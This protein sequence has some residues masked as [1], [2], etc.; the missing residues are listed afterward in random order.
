MKKTIG[1]AGL[2]EKNLKM[3]KKKF[4]LFK[5]LK[6]NDLN[7]FNDLKVDAI[8]IYRE[9][10]VASSLRKFFIKEKYFLFKNLKWFHL[11][12]AGVD[13]YEPSFKKIK[14]I[15]TCGKK[16]QGPNVSE[17]CIAMLLY[18]TRNLNSKNLN[19]EIIEIYNK[20]ALIVGLGSI[21]ISIAEKLN[22]FG[23]K[24]SAITLSSKP[25]YTF[26]NKIYNSDAL[27]KIVGEYDIVINSSALTKITKN[28]F[29]QKIFSKMKKKSYFIN[30]S[31]GLIV[32]T[33]DLLKNIYKFSGVGLDVLDIE[34]V[35]KNHPLKKCKNVLLTNHTAGISDNL[36]RRFDLIFQN[37]KLFKKNERLMNTVNLEEG[38]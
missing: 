13:E 25:F 18:L 30:V 34:P 29:N 33:S 32:N 4:K 3:L 17:H 9:G 11:S 12:R 10:R 8:I 24:V 15:L 35:P 36:D 1:I 26:I 37:L 22:A 14:F 31:R 21:G 27:C 6:L 2:E 5:F 7:F 23:V 20:K 28:I 19:K 38:Y 16:L